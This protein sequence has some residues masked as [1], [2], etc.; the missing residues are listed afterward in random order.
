VLAALTI[1]S[2]PG[3]FVISPLTISIRIDT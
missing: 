3:W 2:N 1:A